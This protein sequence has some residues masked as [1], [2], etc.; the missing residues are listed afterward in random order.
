MVLS[1]EFMDE[2]EEEDEKDKSDSCNESQ[3]LEEAF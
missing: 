1:M 2:E 3:T